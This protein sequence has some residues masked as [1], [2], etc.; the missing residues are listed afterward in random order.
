MGSPT[1]VDKVYSSMVQT[2]VPNVQEASH[3]YGGEETLGDRGMV[4]LL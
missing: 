3:Q 4:S 1:P 2:L